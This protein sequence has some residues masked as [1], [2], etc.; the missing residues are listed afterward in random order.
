[1]NPTGEI[2]NPTQGVLFWVF[3]AVFV[4]GIL[5]FSYSIWG[6]Y[7]LLKLAKPED[8]YD[9][10]GERF[11]RMLLFAFGQKRILSDASTGLMHAFI[12]WGFCVLAIRTISAFAEGFSATSMNWFLNSRFGTGYLYTKDVF[13]ILVT[14]MVLYAAIRRAFVRPKRIDQSMEAY[15]VLLLIFILMITDMSMDASAA[16]L[17]EKVGFAGQMLA[18]LVA[19]LSRNGLSLVYDISWWVHVVTI[20]VFLNLLPG[21]KHF[22]VITAIP[23]VFFQ[24]LTPDGEIA[25]IENL[26]ELFD[27]ED[28]NIPVGVSAITDLSWKQYMDLYSCTEC[29]RCHEFCPTFLTDKPLSPKRVNDELKHFLYEHEKELLS[30]KGASLPSIIGN[31]ISEDEIWDCTTCGRCEEACPIFIEN[32]PRIIDMRR[33]LVMVDANFPSELQQAFTGMERNGNPWNIGMSK[34]FEW[35]EGLEIPLMAEVEN[36]EEIDVLFWVG[37]AGSFDDKGKKIAAA[38]A[39]I[40]EKA[41]VK[42]ACLGEEEMCCGDHARRAGEE[43][44]YQTLA[45]QNVEILN[46]YK[47]KKIVTICPHGFNTMQHEYKAFGGDYQVVHHTEFI[48]DLLKE[49]N[50]ILNN[51]VAKRITYHDSCYLGRQNGIYD[52][53]RTVLRS[54][55]G[56]ELKEAT[57]NREKGLC[58]GAGGGRMFMEE[59][60]GTRINHK[61]LENIV[62]TAAPEE[63]CTACP[64]CM[65]MISDAAN[66]TGL[67]NV[68]T[69]DLAEIVLEA[70]I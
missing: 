19:Q 22:H 23:N 6:Y 15:L 32:V 50:I 43:Y 55:E 37:C 62:K 24:R 40:M 14:V 29:G 42:F 17:G 9:R 65:T 54:I 52:A 34:R 46:G 7:R 18:G 26:E 66:E 68:T 49:G 36:P 8:R 58:C 11:K 12:F 57:L 25:N 13:V 5:Y 48:A 44:L 47:V 20:L 63:I 27:T 33:K 60:R 35:A 51:E 28:E 4:V 59:N 56:V 53:P 38:F 31:A 21:S 1:M 61:R 30:G 41:G 10:I 69:R 39:K 16:V 2:L 45:Q 67:E 64:F 3:V 70:I